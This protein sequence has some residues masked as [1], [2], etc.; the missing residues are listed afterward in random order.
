MNRHLL[1]PL[2]SEHGVLRLNTPKK[3]VL[4]VEAARLLHVYTHAHWHVYTHVYAHACAHVYI[5]VYTH[6]YT[7]VY[8]HAYTQI[9][10]HIYIQGGLGAGN[11]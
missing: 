5:H 4:G 3:A 9:Y 6:T 1:R 7:H 2:P 10:M 11:N 8:I